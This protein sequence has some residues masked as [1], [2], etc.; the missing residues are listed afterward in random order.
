MMRFGALPDRLQPERVAP[1]RQAGERPVHRHPAEDLGLREQ[2]VF[3]SVRA[4]LRTV[5][6]LDSDLADPRATIFGR[7]F[8]QLAV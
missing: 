7:S 3:L 1:G 5:P 2:L 6:E 4:E 8:Y